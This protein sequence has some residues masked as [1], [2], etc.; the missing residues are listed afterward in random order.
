[1]TTE[2]GD[3]PDPQLRELTFKKNNY[4]PIAERVLLRWKDG[5]FVPEPRAGSL[6]KLAE[7]QRAED[8]FLTLLGRF[9]EQGRTLSAKPTRTTTRRPRSL[10]NRA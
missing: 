10:R 5:V 1:M 6:E 8:P 4:G 9:E 3:E 7:D 2:K